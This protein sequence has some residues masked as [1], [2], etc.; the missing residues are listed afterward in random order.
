MYESLNHLPLNKVFKKKRVITPTDFFNFFKKQDP[1]LSEKGVYSRIALLI[2]KGAIVR[3]GRGLYGFSEKSKPKPPF[4]GLMP[5]RGLALY[6]NIKKKF[7]YAEIC[8]WP[9][10]W[11]HSFM[12]HQP[13]SN[14]IIVEPER[15]ACEA[16]FYHLKE[17]EAHVFLNPG[18]KELDYY[19]RSE[20]ESII[21]KP[22]V[23]ESCLDRSGEVMVPTLEKILVDVFKE[24][25]FFLI[26]Q[27]KELDN[28]FWNAFD[29][30]ALNI[31]TM[32]RYARRRGHD[33]ELLKYMKDTIDDVTVLDHY[34]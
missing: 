21:V 17:T 15:E 33:K 5:D 27:G 13:F 24:T 16:V 25:D 28:I 12:I 20:H 29:Q 31:P 19:V 30:F 11:L 3:L 32:V 14:W 23:S 7:H 22:M 2:Q 26:Y 18:K 34:R 9:V 8:I 10:N 6:K 4:Q 1:N